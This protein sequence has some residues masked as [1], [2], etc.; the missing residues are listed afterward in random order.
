M[1]TE[2]VPN[3]IPSEIAKSDEAID[4]YIAAII[5]NGD[6]ETAETLVKTP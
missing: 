1:T 2:Q 5:A 4:A 3:P 6:E